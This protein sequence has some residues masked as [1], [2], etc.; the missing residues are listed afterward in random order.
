M[1]DA[2]FEVVELRRYV[3]HAEQRDAFVALFDREFADSQEA[4]GMVPIGHFRDRDDPRG[5]VWFR[6]FAQF[7][8]RRRALE[9]FYRESRAWKEHRAQ[10]N[11]AL[12][13]NDDVL[14][15][16]DARPG[17]GFD[18]TSLARPAGAHA[19]AQRFVGV[20]VFM[21]ERPAGETF[22]TAFED[23]LLPRLRA[24]A[25]HSAYLVTDSR[26]NE[27]PAL[28]VRE[29]EWAFVV[30]GVCADDDALAAW[31]DLLRA[32]V[33]A[34]MQ[35]DVRSRE[36]LRLEPAPR[37]IYGNAVVAAPLPAR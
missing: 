6:G 27:F 20:A 23:E 7:A 16:R 31:T 12:V 1:P 37:S 11:G 2:T 26:A 28:P 25:Q 10:A 18:L 13:D 32:N 30:A 3:V 19:A 9:A 14:L 34:S 29:G 36:L 33:P 22:I 35:A 24:H 5:F 4:C 21:L 15:L 8:A 17:S